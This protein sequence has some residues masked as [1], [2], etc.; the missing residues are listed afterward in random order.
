I[1]EGLIWATLEHA[2]ILPFLGYYRDKDSEDLELHLVSP[3]MENGDIRKYLETCEQQGD[4]IPCAGLVQGVLKGLIYIHEL[5][6]AHGDLKP[7]NI[8]VNDNGEAQ[9]ADLGI[10]KYCDDSDYT[11]FTDRVAQTIWHSPEVTKAGK[12]FRPSLKSDIWSF[13][14]AWL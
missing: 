10:S 14:C 3:Y 11:E 13:G 4:P 6:I 2:N 8:L 12:R 5:D 1:R 7:S 9:L